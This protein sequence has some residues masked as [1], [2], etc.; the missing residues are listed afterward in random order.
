MNTHNFYSPETGSKSTWE[1]NCEPCHR[2]TMSL[3]FFAHTI[4]TAAGEMTMVPDL[5]KTAMISMSS[6]QDPLDRSASDSP[7]SSVSDRAARDSIVSTQRLLPYST[8]SSAGN[9]GTR[10]S[11]TAAARRDRCPREVTLPGNAALPSNVDNDAV[12]WSTVTSAGGRVTLP[13]SGT[14]PSYL[15]GVEFLRL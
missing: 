2:E 9:D 15:Y 8:P 1:L 12:V 3:Q 11:A 14:Q 13:G 6:P 4:G 5:T 10:R 7:N